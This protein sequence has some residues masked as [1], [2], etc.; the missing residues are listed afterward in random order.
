MRINENRPQDTQFDP[1]S[2]AKRA[3]STK[4]HFSDGATR[5]QVG[6][7]RV[8]VSAVAETA[9]QV[10]EAA[11]GQRADRISHLRAT[12]QSGQY[13]VDAGRL[14]DNIMAAD[15]EEPVV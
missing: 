12:Y 1:T 11:D 15:S 2:N 14:A 10:L 4:S 7:D 5:R 9:T 3:D 6:L 13:Q 8:E